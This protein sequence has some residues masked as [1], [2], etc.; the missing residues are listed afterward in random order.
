MNLR[1]RDSG[2]FAPGP[3]TAQKLPPV[4]LH[5]MGGCIFELTMRSC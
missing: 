5:V 1:R 4:I 3:T 2:E